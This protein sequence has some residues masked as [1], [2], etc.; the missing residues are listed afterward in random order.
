MRYS[1]SVSFFFLRPFLLPTSSSSFTAYFVLDTFFSSRRIAA[2][3]DAFDLILCVHATTQTTV[4]MEQTAVLHC[5]HVVRIVAGT[6]GTEMKKQKE[7]IIR[8]LFAIVCEH[9]SERV[10][11]NRTVQKHLSPFIE[12]SVESRIHLVCIETHAHIGARSILLLCIFSPHR[13]LLCGKCF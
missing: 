12:L 1:F 2:P 9:N 3:L 7:Q 10:R 11:P 13:Y 5:R 8:F 4:E 6:S